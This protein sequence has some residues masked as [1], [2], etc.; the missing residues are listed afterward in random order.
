MKNLPNCKDCIYYKKLGVCNHPIYGGEYPHI[1]RDFWCYYEKKDTLKDQSYMF[2][3][4]NII[5]ENNFW[6]GYKD[7]EKL[8]SQQ[9]NKEEVENIILLVYGG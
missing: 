9:N 6:S 7:N 5:K 3:G 8:I 1:N 2:R 4:W